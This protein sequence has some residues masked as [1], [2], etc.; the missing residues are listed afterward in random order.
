MISNMAEPNTYIL[1][2]GEALVLCG[3]L[4]QTAAVFWAWK[5]WKYSQLALSE[6]RKRHRASEANNVK[7]IQAIWNKFGGKPLAPHPNFKEIQSTELDDL[8]KIFPL[9]G[10]DNELLKRKTIAIEGRFGIGPNANDLTSAAALIADL[11]VHRRGVSEF[12]LFTRQK[13]IERS[14]KMVLAGAALQILGSWPQQWFHVLQNPP[15]ANIQDT[16]K[17]STK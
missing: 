10:D 11:A 5:D 3:I 1:P 6:W 9:S 14:F 4:I 8:A 16:T 7:A 17:P 12:R 15:V 13:T 2:T